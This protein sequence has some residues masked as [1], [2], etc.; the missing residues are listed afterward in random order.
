MVTVEQTTGAGVA[1]VTGAARRIGRAISKRLAQEGYALALHASERSYAEAELLARD[2]VQAGG[3]AHV[4]VADLMETPA[5][6][7]VFE[8]AARTF[9]GV[10]L[11]IN[12]ASLFE[13]DTPATFDTDFF[14]RA[15][16]V[17]L[18]APCAL[19]A[20]MAQALPEGATGAIVNIA[21]QRVWRLNPHFFSYTLTKAA[22]WTATQTMAQAFAPRLRVNAVGPGPVF[23]NVMDGTD[24]FEREAANIPLEQAVA[25]EDV[26]DAVAYLARARSVTGQ[27]IAVDGGQHIAWKT[28]DVTND[29]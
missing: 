9:G 23:P 6:A 12:N 2:I 3:R 25:A 18:R 27:M 19:A 8:Q 26:A 10:T 14:D 29:L 4:I 7:L 28:P 22:L 13:Q 21:D 16:A 20:L 15:M 24:G 1:L 11:L 5:P 17:N